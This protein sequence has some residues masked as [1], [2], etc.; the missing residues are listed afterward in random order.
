MSP[1]FSETALKTI[2]SG[3][4]NVNNKYLNLTPIMAKPEQSGDAKPRVH[5]LLFI[6]RAMD[7]RVTEELA[8]SGA[9]G[10]QEMSHERKR[11]A[12]PERWTFFVL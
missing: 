2:S 3:S 6:D 12:P 5:D 10:H 7:S 1:I 9:F 8:E 4:R 11:P